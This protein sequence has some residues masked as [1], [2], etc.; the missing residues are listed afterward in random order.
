MSSNPFE[1]RTPV[2]ALLSAAIAIALYGA[3]AVVRAQSNADSPAN[4]AAAAEN[5]DA[6]AASK[7]QKD[8]TELNEIVVS[9][10]GSL[11][12]ALDEKRDNTGQVDVIVAEDIGKFPDLNLAESL[13]RIPGVS[14][15][16][17]AGEGRN[18][19]VR[20]LGPVFS[21]VRINGLEALTT[22]GGTDSSG[23]AN[24]GRGFD[25]NIFASELFNNLTVRKT[26]SAEVDEGSLGATVDLTVARPFDYQDFTFV[27]SAQGGY[28]DLSEEFDPRAAMLI[29]NTFADGKFGA[30]LSVAYSQRN[31]SE[32]GHSTVRWDPGTASG[33]FAASS[34][35][36]A[37][38]GATVFHPRIPRYGQ[39]IHDQE[40]LGITTSLQWAPQSGTMLTLDSMFGRFD[41]TR[42][43]NFLEAI[44]FSRTGA[45]GKPATIVLDGEIDS[46]GNLVY[47][48]F[49]NVDIRSESRYDELTTE[50]SQTS[51]NLDHEFSDRFRI[52]AMVGASRSNFKNPI[53]T[54]VTL[55]RLDVDGYSWDYRDNDR[56]PL[57]N[58]GF[59]VNDPAA[60]SFAN[61]RSEIRLRPQSALNEFSTGKI[62]LIFDI[63][64]N[65]VLKGGL[66]WKEYEFTSAEQRRVSETNVTNLPAG[67]SLAELTRL[68]SF[69]AGLGLPAGSDRT[70]LIPDIDAFADLFDIYGNQGIYALT[71]DV[72]SARANN[73]NIKEE[74]LAAYLQL[75]FFTEVGGIPVRGDFGVRQV[76]TDQTSTGFAVVNNVPVQIR[77][78]RDYDDLLPSFNLAADLT[79]D[80]V[81][82]FG[83]AK[84]M[85]RPGLGNLV[86]G[87]TV[88][89]SGGN[90]VVTGGDPYLEPFRAKTADLGLEWYFDEG[91]LLSLAV[92]YKDIDTFVQT[93]RETRPYNTSGL[94]DILLAGTGALPTDEFQFNIPINTPGGDLSGFEISY[95]Q[96]F[97]FL[98]EAWS[99]FG[100]ILNYTFV[101]S[102]IQYN[103][104]AGA[105]SLKTDLNG[106]SKNAYNATVYFER[107]KYS[108]RL[109]GA[110]RDDY[111]TTVPGR[112]GNDV[113]GTK[114]TFNLDMSAS[115]SVNEHLQFV[116]EA[117]N[118]T[119]EYNDQW[120]D[121]AADRSSVYHHTGRQYYAGVRYRF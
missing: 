96:P 52:N 67:I 68:A 53:Q 114:A 24:R 5:T 110:Y 80:L 12:K 115:Y 39:L 120:V 74:D 54:T 90:R 98:P 94:P 50:F 75:D 63:N 86:P 118:L 69:G 100:T 23:G 116:L 37:A 33:G 109:S 81:M 83:V 77:V 13:Q 15:A 82:R 101:K 26:S 108:L 31:L 51:L 93:S 73:H 78:Q 49:D 66:N 14:I 111:L 119:D 107:D 112:N 76:N 85:S 45:A 7:K 32:E 70:W 11:I 60:W 8:A 47:G 22:T 28:N 25:F 21:R 56:V 46:R 99:G 55:D 29:S 89:V 17:D 105:P 41:A 97:N 79:E 44:S 43:E 88:S 38:R 16:R 27:T 87:V 58:Y 113:E 91:S 35:F 48:V 92:F 18:I 102:D 65:L 84:V 36:A 42:T 71:P 117:L 59:D 72:A 40:R 2:V 10:S 106:L 30:L 62:D 6:A 61:G 20:G 34:P 103:T 57:F 19:S 1:K 104:A 4:T 121:S 3:P 95:Q 64:D 9:F